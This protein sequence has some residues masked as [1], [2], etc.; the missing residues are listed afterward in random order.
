[1]NEREEEKSQGEEQLR[2]KDRREERSQQHDRMNE[3]SC[4][5]IMVFP[6]TAFHQ[7]IESNATAPA[8]VD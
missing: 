2:M 8:S 3:K 4:N 1:M 7:P 5:G 6:P